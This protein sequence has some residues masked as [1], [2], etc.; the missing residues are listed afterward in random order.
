MHPHLS[1]EA[2]I[3]EGLKPVYLPGSQG[4]EI[5]FLRWRETHMTDYNMWISGELWIFGERGAMKSVGGR[6]A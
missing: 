5:Q 2:L 3:V 1:V 6:K 4:E